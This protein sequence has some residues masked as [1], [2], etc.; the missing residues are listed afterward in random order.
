M[1]AGP[2]DQTL[3]CSVDISGFGVRGANLG[4]AASNQ[5]VTQGCSVR[6]ANDDQINADEADQHLAAY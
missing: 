6:P 5:L 1:G 3:T 4:R 2:A